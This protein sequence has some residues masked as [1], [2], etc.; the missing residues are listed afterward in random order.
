MASFGQC[1]L[2]V[3][4]RLMFCLLLLLPGLQA[5]SRSPLT[6]GQVTGA[7]CTPACL[8]APLRGNFRWVLA[9]HHTTQWLEAPWRWLLRLGTKTEERGLRK[10]A[11]SSLSSAS[12]SLT[13]GEAALCSSN[14]TRKALRYPVPHKHSHSPR[15]QRSG[16]VLMVLCF[17]FYQF[18]RCLPTS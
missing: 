14:L 7:I 6:S 11:T 8:N 3:S 16:P 17:A 5:V 10:E 1:S 18:S 4:S 12:S 2:A 9:S 13:E 15:A